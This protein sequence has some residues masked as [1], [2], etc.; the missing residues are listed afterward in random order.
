[1]AYKYDCRTIQKWSTENGNGEIL[2]CKHLKRIRSI[3]ISYMYRCG[4]NNNIL[5]PDI[6]SKYLPNEKTIGI[7]P[8]FNCKQMCKIRKDDSKLNFEYSIDNKGNGTDW[9]PL[10][11]KT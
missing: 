1:M 3:G 11:D 5:W 8:Y 9:N 2:K 4:V 6:E 7:S 10:I